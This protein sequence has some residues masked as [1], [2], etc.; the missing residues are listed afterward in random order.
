MNDSVLLEFQDGKYK[1]EKVDEIPFTTDEIIELENKDI[2]KK[3]L[4]IIP[5]TTMISFCPPLSYGYIA[6]LLKSHGFICQLYD[7]RLSKKQQTLKNIIK[8]FDPDVISISIPFTM[9]SYQIISYFNSIKDVFKD[10]PVFIGGAH[11][12]LRGANIL[13]DLDFVTGAIRAEGEYP[14]LAIM[15]GLEL[16]KI[17]GLWYRNGEK[18]IETAPP[19]RIQNLDA[20]PFPTYDGCDINAY[21]RKGQLDIITSRG[22]PFRCT[23]CTVNITLGGRQTLYRT[24]ENIIEEISYWYSKG[25]RLFDFHDDTLNLP[26]KRFL[27]LLDIMI[28]NKFEY[29]QFFLGNAEDLIKDVKSNSIDLILTDPPY[30]LGFG[31]FD[32]SEEFYDLENELWRVAKPNSWLVFY[33]STKKLSEPFS[34]LKRFQFVWQIMA[35]FPTAY[36]RCIV[37]YRKYMP[38]LIF[39]KGNPIVKFKGSD[40]IECFELPCVVEKVRNALFKPTAANMQLLQLFSKENDLILDPF[41]GFGSIPLVTELFKRK[42]IAFEIDQRCYDIATK[43]IK[44]KKVTEIG[45]MPLINNKQREL[46]T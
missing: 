37:G 19:V 5:D 3:L 9:Y 28:N 8:E 14:M 13:E 4:F 10:I 32:N 41:A 7:Q 29:G 20:L 6:E 45:Q 35:Y 11:I 43:F 23:F 1:S 44:N 36:S 2:Y 27:K 46:F 21:G 38:V 30:G 22:C 15:K 26:E 42:W 18:V 40:L 33:W 34:K 16:E 31:E 39:K 17:P 24:P 12:G 25:I